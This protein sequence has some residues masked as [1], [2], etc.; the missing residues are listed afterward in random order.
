MG[1]KR[2]SLSESRFVIYGWRETNISDFPLAAGELIQN[3]IKRQKHL[4]ETQDFQ[5]KGGSV[6]G[7]RSGPLRKAGAAVLGIEACHRAFKIGRG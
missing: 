5:F 7:A 1:F 3:R 6:I 4:P 2:R